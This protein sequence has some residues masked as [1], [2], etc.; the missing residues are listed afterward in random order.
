M[1]RG[2]PATSMYLTVAPATW[3]S[4]SDILLQHNLIFCL[5]Y[6]LKLPSFIL[7]LSLVL[8]QLFLYYL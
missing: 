8:T 4:G 1:K 6:D 2:I 5:Q 7:S 3:R